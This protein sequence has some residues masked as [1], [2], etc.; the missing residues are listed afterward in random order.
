MRAVL[1]APS[2]RTNE[3]W[4]SMN[5]LFEQQLL[6]VVLGITLVL[7][8]GA[9]WSATG[10]K[11]LL[12][13]IAGAVLL[14]VAGLVIERLVVTDR[15]AIEQTLAQIAADV[16]SNHVAAVT[17]H[18][19]SGTPEL[20]QKAAAEMPKYRFT[21]CRITKIHRIDVDRHDD[22]PS[23][24]VEFNIIAAGTFDTPAGQLSDTVPRWVR[25][26]LLQ[27]KDGR[28]TVAE[29]EHDNPQRMLLREPASP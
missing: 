11:E 24:I 8:L 23:A 25:L 2:S 14:L 22:P 5:W 7:L 17:R 20:K 16:K 19:Y 9:A 18:V 6:I 3:H 13:A 4:S 12:F 21:E 10:R 27:E 28:W 29:Y 26:H 1:A 15:E